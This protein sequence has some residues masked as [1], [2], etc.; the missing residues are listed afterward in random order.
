MKHYNSVAFFD[1]DGTLYNGVIGVDFLKQCVRHARITPRELSRLPYFYM[2]YRQDKH[3]NASRYDVNK[4]AY[5]KIK[6]W[7]PQYV[8]QRATDFFG[9]TLDT[10]LF[11]DIAQEARR[12]HEQGTKIVIVTTV[13][14]EIIQVASILDFEPDIIG[15]QVEIK[16]GKYTD[17]I[18]RLPIG[19]QRAVEVEKYCREHNISLESTYGFGDHHSDIPF[20]E[21]VAHATATRPNQVLKQHAQEQNWRIVA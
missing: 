4:Q 5:K 14:Q 2:K 19:E 9:E 3:G 16:N 12:L 17:T 11:K 10:K 1:F 20:L 7:N 15:T 8:A 13:L 18:L 6:G 21:K